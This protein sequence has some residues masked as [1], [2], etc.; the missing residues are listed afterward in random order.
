MKSAAIRDTIDHVT[1]NALEQTNLRLIPENT[2]LVVVRSGILA[3][4][5]PIA[6]TTLPVTFNQD[7]KAIQVTSDAVSPDYLFWSLKNLETHILRQG[8]K[9]GATVHS[10]KSGFLE[11]LTVPLPPLAEQ[12]RI[13]AAIEERLCE[14]E[15]ARAA[16]QAQLDD[17]HAL[18]AAHLRAVFESEEAQGWERQPLGEITRTTSGQTPLRSRSDFYDGGTICW[19][20]TGELRDN[21]IYDTEEHIT[22]LALSETGL[23][24]LPPETVLVAMYGQG[25]TRG[26]TAILKVAAATNQACFAILPQP[27]VFVSEFVQFWFRYQYE[28]LRQESDGR[29]GN[30]PNLNGKLLRAKRVA[31]PSLE[32]QTTIVNELRDIENSIVD[33]QGYLR[34]QLNDIDR[35]P[36]AILRQAFAGEL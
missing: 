6:L 4:T 30:Q 24:C 21:T 2:L 22:E 34:N 17:A 29:G 35:L 26:R 16:V 36:A 1:S 28:T 13:A 11:N 20:K 19:V 33:A 32:R 25:Q 14:V 15:R 10:I 27:S 5:V 7:I 18:M 3:R 23:A 12:R 31:L 8:V 9:I